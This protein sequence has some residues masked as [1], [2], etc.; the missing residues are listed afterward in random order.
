MTGALEVSTCQRDLQISWRDVREAESADG[1]ETF[2][3]ASAY[4]FL[5]EVASGLRS[6]IRGETNVFG[7]LKAAWREHLSRDPE[8]TR[9]L[10]ALGDQLFRDTRDIRTRFLQGVGQHSYAAHA[11]HLLKPEADAR[12]LL[13]G[14]GALGRS[15]VRKFDDLRLAL[16][17]RT[18]PAVL[19]AVFEST[20]AAGDEQRAIAWATHVVMCIPSAPAIDAAWAPALAARPDVPLVHFDVRREARPRW[21]IDVLFGLDD[22]FD[23]ERAQSELRSRQFE[24]AM[25]ACADKALRFET[26]F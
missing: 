8:S 6:E 4:R 11:R 23:L 10:A 19:P 3:A 16:Y 18:T 20:F 24:G 21:P 12:V 17:N 7:Q 1:W 26:R 14:Y 22:I 9:D 13:V 25:A 5:L 15:M 2:R